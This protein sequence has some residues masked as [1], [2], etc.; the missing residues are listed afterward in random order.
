VRKEGKP[1][2]KIPPSLKYNVSKEE[3]QFL[4]NCVLHSRETLQMWKLMLGE[5]FVEDVDVY[6]NLV[7]P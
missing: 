6:T 5:D 4:G 2:G 1:H 3:R 7:K